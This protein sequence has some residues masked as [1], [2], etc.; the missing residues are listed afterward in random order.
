VLNQGSTRP[1]T[2]RPDRA[3]RHIPSAL[4]LMLG[5][6]DV[7]PG[8]TRALGSS[9]DD[10]HCTPTPVRRASPARGTARMVS[11][12]ALCVTPAC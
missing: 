9:R 2:G 11:L 7:P 1:V 5:N 3:Q 4:V 8:G 10:G 6:A 12:S